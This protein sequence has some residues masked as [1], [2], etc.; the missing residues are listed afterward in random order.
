MCENEI[1]KKANWSVT[2]TI[3]Y[4]L[5]ILKKPLLFFHSFVCPPNTDYLISR[6]EATLGSLDKVK[7]GHTDYLS[8]MGGKFALLLI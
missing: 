8:N 2:K 3:Y 6:A 1:C 5:S 7:K 4:I